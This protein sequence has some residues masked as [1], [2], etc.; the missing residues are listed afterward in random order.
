MKLKNALAMIQKLQDAGHEVSLSVAVQV[1]SNASPSPS[2]AEESPAK[3]KSTGG[4]GPGRGRTRSEE[5]IRREKYIRALN[6]KRGSKLTRIQAAD[7]VAEKF[8]VGIDKAKTAVYALKDIEWK[9]AQRGNPNLGKKSAE[10]K[11]ASKRQEV[12]EDFL[13][14]IDGDDG[15]DGDDP[16]DGDDGDDGDDVLDLDNFEID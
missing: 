14:D 4:K 15:D 5:S 10:K 9:K 11:Q 8:E 16:D 3:T 2:K 13:K 1:D 6:E 7:M 12:E